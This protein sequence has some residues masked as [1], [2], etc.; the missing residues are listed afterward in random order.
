MLNANLGSAPG[1]SSLYKP[2][3]ESSKLQTVDRRH[4]H[5]QVPEVTTEVSEL[6]RSS[7]VACVV[8]RHPGGKDL[9][10]WSR[11]PARG[12]PS[13]NA[14]SLL[15]AGMGD[16]VAPDSLVTPG[17]IFLSRWKGDFLSGRRT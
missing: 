8:W 3:G 11:G 2:F 15:P 5:V 9:L 17:R 16:H 10:R 4:E 7:V 14:R 1:N 6:L 12:C 13:T